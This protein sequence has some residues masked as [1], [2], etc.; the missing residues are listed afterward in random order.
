[1]MRTFAIAAAL[2]GCISKPDRKPAT[3]DDGHPPDLDLSNRL[4][5]SLHADNS[6]IGRRESTR[7]TYDGSAHQVLA[8]GGE[9]SSD[10]KDDLWGLTMTGWNIIDGTPI[11]PTPHLQ[12]GFAYDP[13][14]HVDVLFGG[15]TG[16]SAYQN[17]LWEHATTWMALSE[18]QPPPSRSQTMLLSAGNRMFLFGGYDGSAMFDV[19]E[20]TGTSWSP[21]M[22]VDGTATYIASP[23]TGVTWDADQQRFLALEGLSNGESAELHAYDPA[24][25]AWSTVCLGCEGASMQRRDASIVHIPGRNLTL[26]IGGN[27]LGV[28]VAGTMVLN[29]DHWEVYDAMMPPG[30]SLAGVVY[31]PDQDAVILYGGTG[32]GANCATQCSDTFVL[33]P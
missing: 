18:T 32:S 31:D 6:T 16:N 25:D 3:P 27:H 28:E 10:I 17:D 13:N 22:K 15:Y 11:A 20:L 8:Y 9:N 19:W 1:M 33:A 14:T 24:T 30:R 2:A 29:Q 12:P 7:L 23:G 21:R 4:H 5:W 26:L